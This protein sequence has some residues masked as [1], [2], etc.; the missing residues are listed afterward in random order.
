MLTARSFKNQK[1]KN[2]RQHYSPWKKSRK[3]ATT[4]SRRKSK[5]LTHGVLNGNCHISAKEPCISVKEPCISAKEP[6]ISTKEPC[7]SAK[8]PCISAKE[9][10]MSAKEPCISA[11]ARRVSVSRQ[12]VKCL[13][14]SV[15]R[16]AC[17]TSVSRMI[18]TRV[19]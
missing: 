10:C 8:E 15:S 19:F 2:C 3:P 17:L 13:E 1:T 14:T 5:F 9:P 12:I 16:D 11:N 4:R 6:C 18:E 7:I